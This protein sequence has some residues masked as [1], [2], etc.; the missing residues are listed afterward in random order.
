MQGGTDNVCFK[1]LNR[2][3]EDDQKSSEQRPS[4]WYLTNS[5]RCVI[6]PGLCSLFMFH[7]GE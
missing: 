4:T 7:S 5:A 1:M 2:R 6:C 3:F